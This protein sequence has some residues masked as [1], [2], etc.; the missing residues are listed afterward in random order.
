MLNL[1]L[2]THYKSGDSFLLNA[3]KTRSTFKIVD[4]YI[5]ESNNW[6]EHFKL[7]VS[8]LNIAYKWDW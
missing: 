6:P 7:V 2:K 5:D 8:L 1:T 4:K 3:E